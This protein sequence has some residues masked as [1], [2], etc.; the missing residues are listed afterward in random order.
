[1]IIGGQLSKLTR[2]DLMSGRFGDSFERVIHSSG[3]KGTVRAII[4][5]RR[6]LIKN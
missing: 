3:W 5:H 2:L 1:M 6:E 4:T